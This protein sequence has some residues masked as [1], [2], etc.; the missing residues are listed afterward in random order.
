MHGYFY[1]ISQSRYAIF[2]KNRQ[3]KK[4]LTINTYNIMKKFTILLILIFQAATILPQ[5]K[6]LVLLEEFTNTGCNPCARFAPILDSL[7]FIRLG[8]VVSVKYH[9]NYPD[10]DDQFFL[11][12][13]DNL[14][15]RANHYKITGV[16]SVFID[17]IQESQSPKALSDAIDKYMATPEK[18]NMTLTSK[19]TDNN[20]KINVEFTPNENI[21]SSDLALFV[22]VLEEEIRLDKPSPNGE[23]HYYNICRKILPNGNGQKLENDLEKGKTYKYDFDWEISGFFNEKELGLIAFI[24][25]QT[26]NEVLHTVYSPRNAETPEAAKVILV[27]DTPDKICTPVFYSKIMFRNTGSNTITRANINVMV[28]GSIQTT[29]WEG[30]LKYLETMTINTEDFTDFEL[31]DTNSND[32]KIWIS[33][34]NG[35]KSESEK[36][37]MTFSNSA[38][39]ENTAQLSIFTDKK[40]EETTWKLYNS[41]GGLVDE[42]GPYTEPRHL[43]QEMLNI[44]KDDCYQIV[45]FDKGKDGICGE[46]GNGYFKLE[47]IKTDGKK[48]IIIQ[49][50]YDS[51]SFIIQFKMMNATKS[52]EDKEYNETAISFGKNNDIIA[53]GITKDVKIEIFDITGCSIM[54]RTIT[55]DGKYEVNNL[56]KGIYIM[57]YHIGEETHNL[58]IRINYY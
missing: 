57:Q 27:Q 53:K 54:T 41:A 47:Q 24:Q 32:V 43:Y 12:D 2:T 14:T 11:Q 28:N 25:D 45:F 6:R 40:P 7:L 39:V 4:T 42:G 10:S 49:D 36:Y 13:R 56:M 38:I 18:M 58:K 51:E 3:G 29:P 48:K 30:N 44:E 16:P 23:Y 15:T 20:L 52:I 31:S 46:H 21:S 9:F 8:D 26:T 17:G 35:T 19:N 22:I 50:D 34:I 33:D 55:C 37:E 1:F 5:S